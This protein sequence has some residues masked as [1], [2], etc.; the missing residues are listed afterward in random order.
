VYD[1]V[2]ERLKGLHPKVIDLALDRI[3]RLLV[4][5][6]GPDHRLPPVVHIAGTNG[7]GSTVA[8][9]RAMFAATGR[10]AHA[11]TSPHLVR[12]AERIEVAGKIISDAELTAVLEECERA[13]AGQP[14]TFF[15]ITTAAAFLA[16]ARHPADVCLLETGLGGRYDATNVL[17]HPALTVLTPISLDHQAFLGNTVAAIA[18]EK[19]GILKEGTP[20]VCA[21]QPP[22]A[23]EV[24]VAQAK[25]LTVPLL[26]EDRDWSVEATADGLK[27]TMGERRLTLPRPALLGPHQLH[28]A[29][30]AAACAV[31]LGETGSV[32]PL[33]DVAIGTGLR[34]AKWPARL[35]R[36]TKGPLPIMMPDGWELWLDG[37][38]NPSAG[39]ALAAMA[40]HWSDR[41]LDL[42][43]GMLN[44]KDSR[45]FLEPLAPYVRAMRTV[46]IPGEENSLSAEQ[47]A[48][49]AVAEGI[50][51]RPADS[52]GVAVAELTQ[53]SGPAR[54]LICGSLY[55]AGSIL[56]DNG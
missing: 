52:A 7:K 27:L 34:T 15:E 38:H 43:V 2:L 48:A 36:L 29:G 16:F 14:I 11:Y 47:T 49:T 26:V 13:N 22:E 6:D 12:F 20:C 55:L 17:A 4:A 44:T 1:T 53:Q 46:A 31:V 30:L 10:T 8:Y 45:G 37:G 19:A 41:P 33:S 28:N 23:L 18:G 9:L 56:A 54:L 5:L 50:V 32:P 25:A 21:A 40:R 35:Q 51:A 42:L 24:I 39:H 3:E